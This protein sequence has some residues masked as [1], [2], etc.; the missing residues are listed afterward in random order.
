MIVYLRHEGF[1][2]NGPALGIQTNSVL[3]SMK[4]PSTVSH[5]DHICENV[6][7]TPVSGVGYDYYILSKSVI[8]PNQLVLMRPL[9]NRYD[10]IVW[11][12]HTV[13]LDFLSRPS[14]SAF[15]QF[16]RNQ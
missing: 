11:I 7:Y 16:R 9:R 2:M 15:D 8:I 10:P 6:R 4:P 5:L 14:L 13:Q 12:E 1:E 3:G